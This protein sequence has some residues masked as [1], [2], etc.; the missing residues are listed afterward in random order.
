MPILVAEGWRVVGI[1][2]SATKTELLKQLGAHLVV[3]DVF[4]APSLRRTITET[5]PDIVIHQ[6]TDLPPRLD[7]S[8]AAWRRRR[9]GTR[10]FG[11]KVHA[12]W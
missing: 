1:T 6:L 9:F 10:V 4:D 8:R 5:R 2:R 11:T 7:P 12:I 3:I